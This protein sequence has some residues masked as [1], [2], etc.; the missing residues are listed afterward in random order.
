M[1]SL[2]TMLTIVLLLVL[3]PALHARYVRVSTT[4]R[5]IGA[6]CGYE[7]GVVATLPL[8]SGGGK[9]QTTFGEVTV[10]FSGDNLIVS[11]ST[12]GTFTDALHVQVSSQPIDNPVPGRFPCKAQ[13]TGGAQTLTC[14]LSDFPVESCCD[15]L[16]IYTHG[17]VDGET[18]FAGERACT[19]PDTRWCNVIQVDPPCGCGC[20]AAAGKCITK[21]ECACDPG[22]FVCPADESAQCT[23]KQT[24]PCSPFEELCPAEI[25]TGCSTQ[26]IECACDPG[27]FVCPADEPTE[28][29]QKGTC[30]CS[31]MEKLCPADIPTGCSTQKEPCQCTPTQMECPAN[32][33]NCPATTCGAEEEVC[34][35]DPCKCCP[36]CPLGQQSTLHGGD[37]S[38]CCKL[39]QKAVNGVCEELPAGTCDACK[40]AGGVDVCNKINQNWK[41]CPGSSECMKGGLDLGG[42]NEFTCAPACGDTSNCYDD[43]CWVGFEVTGGTNTVVDPIPKCNIPVWA[44]GKRIIRV[45]V[46]YCI[47]TC[48]YPCAVKS[49][50]VV[51]LSFP[52][53]LLNLTKVVRSLYLH[54]FYCLKFTPSENKCSDSVL[55]TR[56]FS[57]NKLI[58]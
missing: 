11:Y 21:I 30:P 25:P 36:K 47:F 33:G 40:D 2:T 10:A 52:R 12:S 18:V 50:I 49:E 48:W 14:P 39:C 51:R 46:S 55:G 5:A 9:T 1:A 16:Y 15:T 28:C 43:V 4:A 26:K 19:A 6:Y 23:Q 54:A 53:R 58:I 22:K 44:Y 56:Q 35:D 45:R 24:C 34:A 31:P 37:G 13:A 32:L 17:V 38:V 29:T 20:D 8:V 3:F 57:I 27:K 7:D 41:C 42:T